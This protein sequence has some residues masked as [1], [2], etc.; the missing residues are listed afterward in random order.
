MKSSILAVFVTLFLSFFAFQTQANAAKTCTYKG[1]TYKAGQKVL[2]PC[3]TCYCSS[4][5]YVYCKPGILDKCKVCRPFQGKVYKWGQKVI[6]PRTRCYNC[7]CSTKGFVHCVRK[8]NWATCVSCKYRGKGYKYGQKFRNGCHD[9]MCAKAGQIR[10]KLSNR[11]R[12]CKFEGKVYKPNQVWKRIRVCACL[13]GEARCKFQ[14][15]P[16]KK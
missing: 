7:Y 9:C 14:F 12:P 16:V 1:R 11:C 2:N 3:R 5:G 8:P 6:T 4:K 13:N 15:V 10:C